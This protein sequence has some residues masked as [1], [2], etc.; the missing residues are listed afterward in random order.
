M[1]LC[2]L[3]QAGGPGGRQAGTTANAA[4]RPG[5]GGGGGGGPWNAPATAEE[6][7]SLAEALTPALRLEA[8]LRLA[9]R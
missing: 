8:M 1:R 7:R 4:G 5:G 9:N 6:R 2:G 3:E